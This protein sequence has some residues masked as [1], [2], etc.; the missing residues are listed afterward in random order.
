RFPVWIWMDDPSFYGFPVWPDRALKAAQ[1]VG[2][3][4]V[5]PTT[6]GFDPT[7]APPRRLA[8]FLRPHLPAAGLPDHSAT[9]LYP[10]TPDRDLVSAPCPATTASWS[11][12]AARTG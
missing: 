9:C 8:G 5:T 3:H 11:P 12:S 1:D 7:P 10:L 6:R 2:G 4:Q